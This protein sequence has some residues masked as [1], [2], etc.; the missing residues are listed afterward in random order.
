M[1]HIAKGVAVR[2][3]EHT[4]LLSLFKKA[5]EKKRYLSKRYKGFSEKKINFCLTLSFNWVYSNSSDWVEHD[6]YF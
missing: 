1:V 3:T 4:E 5:W 2:E 6:I